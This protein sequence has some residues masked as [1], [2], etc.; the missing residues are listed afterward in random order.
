MSEP[1]KVVAD[2]IQTF[3]GLTD[4]QVMLAY[5]RYEIPTKGLYI[6]LTP[7]ADQVISRDNYIEDIGGNE[8]EVTDIVAIHDIQ[9]DIMSFG[10]EARQRRMEVQAALASQ[11]SQNAQVANGLS[12]ARNLMPIQD[13]SF[14]EETEFLL[15]F[16]TRIRVTAL[17]TITHSDADYY[18]S[19]TGE[20][21][22]DPPESQPESVDPAALTA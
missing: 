9:I 18:D 12:I 3:M 7:I 6:V 22:L 20:L 5:Q 4:G 21:N 19:F 16:T 2:I 17:T 1:I 13:T 8:S 14:L 15:R 10:P 11:Y